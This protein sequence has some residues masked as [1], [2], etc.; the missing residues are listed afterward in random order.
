[1]KK[2]LLL[3]IAVTAGCFSVIAQES[4]EFQQHAS[5]KGVPIDGSL[6]AFV[7]NMKL[8]G[9]TFDR[10]LEDAAI[11]NGQ[12]VGKQCEIYILATPK[13][14]TVWKVVALLPKETSWHSLKSSY[15]SLKSSYVDK[16]GPPTNSFE[17]FSRPYYEGDG[18][19]MTALHVEKCDYISFWKTSNSNMAVQMTKDGRISLGYEDIINVSSMNSNSL[20]YSALSYVSGSNELIEPTLTAL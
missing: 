20:T 4:Q 12:F 16:Y 18:Y 10:M 2:I 3:L 6:D 8:E 13:T 19:E 15:Q 11:M 7:E 9:F 1:M 5:F 14:K 17:F